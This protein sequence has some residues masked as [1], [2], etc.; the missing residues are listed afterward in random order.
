MTVQYKA[1]VQPKFSVYYRN[2]S[3]SW[4]WFAESAYLA[5]ASSYTQATYTTPAMPSDAT[6]ISI[7]LSIFNA[8]SLTSDAYTLVADP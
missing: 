1:N 8:G 4:V 7:G 5:T 6:A 2:T 3:G